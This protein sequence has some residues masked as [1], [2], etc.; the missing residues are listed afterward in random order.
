MAASLGSRQTPPALAAVFDRLA[1]CRT[2][3]FA[4]GA[5]IFGEGEP[6][7]FVYRVLSGVVRTYRLLSDGRRQICD[8]LHP[9]DILGPE[10]ALAH[11]NTAE[12]VTEAVLQA[13]PRRALAEAAESDAP[14][15]G[16]LWR[17]SV[18]WFQRS[19]DHAM[20]LARQGAV[21]RVVCFLL[22]YAAR[23]GAEREF[24]LPMT[25]QDIADHLG[26]TIH[27]V[28]RTMSQL[29]ADGLVQLESLRHVR[30]CSLPDLQA[31]S[32]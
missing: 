1:G 12:A 32:A 21:E 28:S 9:G 22:A 5:E 29:Q 11:R 15:A 16:D 2:R 18:N 24:D 23:V 10:A 26:L 13:I 8:F 14:L 31:I 3:S 7:D 19:E 30:L 25:R 20:V 27:T 4:P 6:A 17:L